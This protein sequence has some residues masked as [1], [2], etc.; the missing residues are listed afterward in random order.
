MCCSLRMHLATLRIGD[1]S[2]SVT[3][4]TTDRPSACS[5]QQFPYPHDTYRHSLPFHVAEHREIQLAYCLTDDMTRI[6][7]ALKH[8]HAGR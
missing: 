8:L 5:S 3:V 4:P 1:L 6:F 7:Y 2:A